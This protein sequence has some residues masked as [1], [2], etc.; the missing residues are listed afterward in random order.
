M[1]KEKITRTKAQEY[2]IINYI[3]GKGFDNISQFAQAVGMERQNVWARIKG[4]TD[5][6]IRM[7]MRWAYI[8]NADI[9]ELI[10]LF[11]PYEWQE[12]T[13]RKEKSL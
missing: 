10:A 8:L 9:D 1:R 13:N 6:D 12:Y 4:K 7:L 5:P 3:Q 11:Y 2:A